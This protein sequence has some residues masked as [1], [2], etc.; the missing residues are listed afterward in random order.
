[1]ILFHSVYRH[2]AKMYLFFVFSFLA[3]I[4]PVDEQR[5]QGICRERA[6]YFIPCHLAISTGEQ[7][8]YPVT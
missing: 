5:Q 1:M 6:R 4:D 3:E 8:L 2:V 7:M